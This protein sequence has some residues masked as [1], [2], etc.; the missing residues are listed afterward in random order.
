MR[1]AQDL[2]AINKRGTRMRTKITIHDNIIEK[3][4][5]LL[6]RLKPTLPVGLKKNALN[7][8]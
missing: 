7:L 6:V 5:T 1:L 8:Y 2:F 3:D 4:H